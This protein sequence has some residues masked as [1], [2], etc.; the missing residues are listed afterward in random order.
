MQCCQLPRSGSPI[1]SSV[2]V[3][4][5]S[6]LS[7]YV[8]IACRS[9]GAAVKVVLFSG[10]RLVA[11]AIGALLVELMGF[12]L[13]AICDQPCCA[14]EGVRRGAPDLMVLDPL[15]W[16]ADWIPLVDAFVLAN[17][18]GRVVVLNNDGTTLEQHPALR[19]CAIGVLNSRAGWPELITTLV[20]LQQRLESPL[21][22]CVPVGCLAGLLGM[23]RLPQRERR[24]LME[25]GLGLQN[26]QIAHNLG[27][28]PATVGT[29][30]K[31]I[32]AKLGL[33]GAELVRSAAL[34]RCWTWASSI[35]SMPGC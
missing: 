2:F 9:L 28:T 32:A 17:P 11:Q 7:A 16:A 33:S 1:E 34:Y 27:L 24:M 25:L 13:L 26:K 22:A 30:R 29:Y 21:E 14:L 35:G 31:T 6:G 8:Y 10:Q 20:H 12:E 15:G 19:Q 23:D 3:V 5:I 18:S 4:P